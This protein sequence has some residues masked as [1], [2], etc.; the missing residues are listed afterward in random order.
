MY[1]R[2]ALL[3]SPNDL[4]PV[5]NPKAGKEYLLFYVNFATLDYIEAIIPGDFV[6][7]AND[8]S[9]IKTIMGERNISQRGFIY[10]R[11]AEVDEGFKIRE[12]CG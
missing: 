7:P 3:Y 1:K 11:R 10:S 6:L 4:T 8:T 9:T 2:Q 12:G 5:K